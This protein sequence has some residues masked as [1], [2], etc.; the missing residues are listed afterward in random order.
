MTPRHQAEFDD[1][2]VAAGAAI[3]LA[4]QAPEGTPAKCQAWRTARALR[5]DLCQEIEAVVLLERGIKE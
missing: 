4:R 3:A 1:E 2:I 5:A